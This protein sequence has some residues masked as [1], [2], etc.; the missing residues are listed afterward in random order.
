MKKDPQR[1]A[2]LVE[3]MFV[4]AI[5]GIVLGILMSFLFHSKEDA[6]AMES[7]SDLA[8]IS[9]SIDLNLHQ[10]VA[11]SNRLLCQIA[12]PS[13]TAYW[14]IISAGIYASATTTAGHVPAP[15]PVAWGVTPTVMTFDY[16]TNTVT[17]PQDPNQWAAANMGNMLV[18]VAAVAP[19][20]LSGVPLTVLPLTPTPNPT[21]GAATS[22]VGNVTLDRYQFVEIYL[23][24]DQSRPI[25]GLPG[26]LRLVEW[27]S[28]PYVSY[29]ELAAMP[30]GI[31][32]TQT[33]Q[34]LVAMGY[35]YAYDF[36]QAAGDATQSFHALNTANP[37][38]MTWT[39]NALTM[40]PESAWGY[41]EEYIDTLDPNPN[42][43]LPK[44]RVSRQSFNGGVSSFPVNYSIAYNTNTLVGSTAV[45]VATP[46]VTPSLYQVAGLFGGSLAVLQVPVYAVPANVTNTASGFPGGFEVGVFGNV[47]RREIW[48]RTVVMASAGIDLQN[49]SE[50]KFP[51]AD[52]LVDVTI[53]NPD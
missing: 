6:V 41:V 40:V 12:T 9:Q 29:V 5:M 4:L 42:P 7:R 1:G 47:N 50:K 10:S 52:G 21:P 46:N 45:P 24:L 32:L 43:L 16:L 38:A 2:S 18:F 35:D 30:A 13:F 51:A 23:S 17:S 48:I 3:L 14:K 20:H 36:A 44:G 25:P 53:N 34:T 8:S 22:A 19:L 49:L 37:I 28:K 33:V 39:A 15:M 11:Q 31:E 27:R 26:R